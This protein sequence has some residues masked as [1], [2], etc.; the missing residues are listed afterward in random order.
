[1]FCARCACSLDLQRDLPQESSLSYSIFAMAIQKSAG[2]LSVSISV[3]LV[4]VYFDACRSYENADN[5]EK[6]TSL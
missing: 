2:L 3:A 5:F 6:D 4:F 1:M